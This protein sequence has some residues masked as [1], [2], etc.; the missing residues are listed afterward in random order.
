M[1]KRGTFQSASALNDVPCRATV[2]D[3]PLP[4]AESGVPVTSTR[5]GGGEVSPDHVS[6]VQSPVRFARIIV[7]QVTEAYSHLAL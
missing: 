2:T 7:V 4:A 1:E 5:L 6:L 3:A